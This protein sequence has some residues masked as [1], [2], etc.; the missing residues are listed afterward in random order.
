MHD[1]QLLFMQDFA[2]VK[3]AL[4]CCVACLRELHNENEQ[5]RILHTCM[6]SNVAKTGQ[7][8]HAYPRLTLCVLEIVNRLGRAIFCDVTR[9]RHT[10][11]NH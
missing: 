1:V 11:T 5:L 8:Q 10:V 7:R 9:R 3:Y 6:S 4:H 2:Q